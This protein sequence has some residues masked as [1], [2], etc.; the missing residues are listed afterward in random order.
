LSDGFASS[1]LRFNLSRRH[2]QALVAISYDREVGVDIEYVRAMPVLEIAEHSFAPYEVKVLRNLP[3]SSLIEAFYNCWT[4]KEA[5]IKARGEG[6]SFP[7]DKF[8]VSLIPGESARLLNVD[9]NTD[10][11]NRWS[12]RDIPVGA[13]YVAALAVAV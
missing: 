7:L 3:E 9:D 13:S 5:Y 6:L 8:A 4:R 12:L 11:L 10:E 2:G 1:K